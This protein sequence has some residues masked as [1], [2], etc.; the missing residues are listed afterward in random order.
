MFG[1][2]LAL[3]KRIPFRFPFPV[4]SVDMRKL[5][6]APMVAWS[7]FFCLGIATAHYWNIP[8]VLLLH[9]FVLCLS[10]ALIFLKNPRLSY[11]FL[12]SLAFLLGALTLENSQTQ[13]CDAIANLTPVRKHTVTLCGVVSSDPE[14]SKGKMTFIL[15]A[16][17]LD[18]DNTPRRVRGKVFV[19]LWQPKDISYGDEMI[20]QGGLFRPFGAHGNFLKSKG[21]YS[22]LNVK[23]K[24]SITKTGRVK[25]NPV[26]LLAILLKRKMEHI[27]SSCLTPFSASVINAM[28][29]G[30]SGEILPAV[31]EDMI[32][33]GTWHVMV[34]SGSNTAFA[35][36]IILMI[37]KVIRLPKRA[38]Y[39]VA[40]GILVVY[41]LVTGASSPVLRATVMTI[42]LL[43]SYVSR[44]NPLIY[45]SLSIAAIVL[46]GFDPEA[47]FQM[48]FQLSFVSVLFIA[49]LFPKMKQLFPQGALKCPIFAVLITSICVSASA[50]LG[51]APLIAYAFGNF[52]VVAVLANMAVVPLAMLVAAGGFAMVA[53]GA[54]FPFLVKFIAAAN[55]FLI[56]VF[57]KTNL[58]FAGLPYASLQV[59]HFPRA[60]LFGYYLLMFLVF[61]SPLFARKRP[62]NE[63]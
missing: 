14:V 46:L 47:L 26:K 8:V 24:D 61:N 12:F 2:G 30:E 23:T 45:N 48:S 22:I 59:P 6:L 51:T 63:S 13:S 35:A 33:T 36:F 53:V 38:R 62:E 28:L 60:L 52:S 20:L 10:L 54:G 55:E 29:L 44:R 17:E 37:L 40:M 25:A 31:R 58:F 27:V 15:E 16:F 34:V 50:W 3:P 19:R 21:I 18:Y 32:K 42:A 39:A 1:Q 9:I 56:A 5:S 49:W 7:F 4:K 41:C 57:L 11:F 43:I